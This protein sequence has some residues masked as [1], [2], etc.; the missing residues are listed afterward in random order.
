[1]DSS[2]AKGSMIELTVGSV[3]SEALA[4]VSMLRLILGSLLLVEIMR[5]TKGCGRRFTATG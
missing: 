4:D 2:T 3:L 1:M 5:L